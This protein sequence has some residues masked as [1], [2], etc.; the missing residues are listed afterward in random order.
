MQVRGSL[1]RWV[2]SGGCE[3]GCGVCVGGGC[4]WVFMHVGV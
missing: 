3:G 1:C 2:C 4:K